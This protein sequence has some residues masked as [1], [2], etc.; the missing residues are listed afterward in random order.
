[1]NSYLEFSLLSERSLSVRLHFPYTKEQYEFW[2]ETKESIL[3]TLFIGSSIVLITEEPQV[4]SLC[5]EYTNLFTKRLNHKTFSYDIISLFN[6][7]SLEDI[8]QSEE[9][10]RNLISLTTE[11]DKQFLEATTL[12]HDQFSYEEQTPEKM[13]QSN[14][15]FC[16]EDGK[17][18]YIFNLEEDKIEYLIRSYKK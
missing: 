2:Q 1:M 8:I 5:K 3:R 17:I 14:L 15:V 7:K 4:Y 9:F 6:D 11:Q 10:D 13:L 18:L 12:W 16:D